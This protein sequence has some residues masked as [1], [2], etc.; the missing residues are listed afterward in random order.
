MNAETKIYS[1]FIKRNNIIVTSWGYT[2][3]GEDVRIYKSDE[4]K[5][6][7][8]EIHQENCHTKKAAIYYCLQHRFKVVN[9]IIQ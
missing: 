7:Y 3:S 8:S 6:W 1:D 9:G 5:W 4:S 2:F